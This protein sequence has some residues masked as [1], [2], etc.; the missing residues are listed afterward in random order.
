[1]AFLF[2]RR[3]A[4]RAGTVS[5][6]PSR[7]DM[8]PGDPQPGFRHSS[9]VDGQK[10]S[11]PTPNRR[12]DSE[13]VIHPGLHPG[14][15]G[16][17][18]ANAA[19]DAGQ[20]EAIRNEEEPAESSGK[21]QEP[22][23]D[24]S[25]FR[26]NVLFVL[27]C[28]VFLA[29]WCRA[30]YLQLVQGEWLAAKARRQHETTEVVAGRRGN[31]MDRDGNV[32][33]RSVE[34]S[35][36]YA[37]PQE[38]KDP[39]LTAN[40]L[41]PILGINPQ[42][43]YDKLVKY[44]N[45]QFVYLKRQVDD[46]TVAGVREAHLPGIALLKEYARVYPSTR[47]AGQLLGF[48][49]DKE[50][51]LE[52]LER[53]L[54]S[55]LACPVLGE[56]VVLRDAAGR[57]LYMHRDNESDPHGEDLHLTINSQL[58]FFAEDAIAQAVREAK[59]AWGGALVVDVPTGEILVWAQYPYFNPN[60]FA[61][62]TP[63]VYRNRL[64]Q[65]ALEPGSTFKPLVLAAA[66][67]QRVVGRDTPINCEGGRW[68]TK[69]SV[70]RDTSSRGTIP[71]SKVIRY[72]SNI[73]MAKIGLM[74]GSDTMYKYLH[75][76]GFGENTS[77]PV[78]QSRG[79]LR[80]PKRWS[81]VDTMS[82]S[83]GQGVS[84]TPLQMAQA[85]LTLLNNGVKKNLVLV[86][87]ADTPAESKQIFSRNVT[88]EIRRM[89]FEV[90]NEKDGTGRRAA[91]EGVEVA[92]KTGTAQ[93]ADRRAGAYGSKRLASFVGFLPASNPKYLILVFIDEPQSS[94]WGGV[95][96]APVFREIALRSLAYSG[97]LDGNRIAAGDFAKQEGPDL[98][99]NDGSR[100][101]RTAGISSPFEKKAAEK[102]KPVVMAEIEEPES[103]AEALRLP[104]HMAKASATV[105]DVIGKTVRNA[106]ELFARAGIMPELK[107][108]GT[109][110][111]RQEPPP[112]TPWPD[113]ADKDKKVSYVLW[114]SGG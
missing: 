6:E 61:K 52:G 47:V 12:L 32:L 72:S 18:L 58:Q 45:K 53:S 101:Y 105:P 24:G 78:S 5:S 19:I 60:A 11:T 82:I 29:L 33:A 94:K 104:G 66:M 75:E 109:R 42:N 28:L 98:Q 34:S 69:Y 74:M 96:A 113:D 56:R 108:E 71:V 80:A 114:L 90:V 86:R 102:K 7:Q 79:I 14:H 3:R 22:A 43:I 87:E 106:V 107:G 31:I 83:F 97:E 10:I 85:Y 49:G 55:R 40:T 27:L 41:G 99:K 63:S 50:K 2:S 54:D 100:G 77:V 89:M 88:K 103:N 48:V 17:G 4:N 57:H 21:E 68:Q 38:V 65:D 25:R 112:G 26:I 91:I 70:L 76:L 1:M 37:N 39:L 35:S 59:A 30:A 73:G 84:V 95:I 64:A 67:Q 36:V 51:G 110:V 111:V 81:E 23:D 93:K 44:R 9:S 92:G 20:N 13:E 8:Q 16:E 62:A 15:E 46:Y